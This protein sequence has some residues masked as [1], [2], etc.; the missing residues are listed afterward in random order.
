MQVLVA[1]RLLGWWLLCMWHLG[2]PR[3]LPQ[4]P[5][6]PV[7]GPQ[8]GLQWRVCL[9]PGMPHSVTCHLPSLQSAPVMRG[10]IATS[11]DCRGT[12]NHAQ[13]C[14]KSLSLGL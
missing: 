8:P 4:L 5:G 10:V 9:C 3:Q 11:Q 2:G 12:S 1:W 13:A 14:P 7:L 6:L